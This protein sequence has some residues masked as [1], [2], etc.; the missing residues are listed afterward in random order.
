M[1]FQ[2][3]CPAELFALIARGKITIYCLPIRYNFSIIWLH[4]YWLIDLK[5]YLLHL[6]DTKGWEEETGDRGKGGKKLK[7]KKKTVKS[8]EE[9]EVVKSF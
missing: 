2:S 6:D 4:E 5:S 9:I 1:A 3:K 8:M 7:K